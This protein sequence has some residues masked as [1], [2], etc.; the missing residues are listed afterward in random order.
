M[1]DILSAL[2]NELKLEVVKWHSKY[3]V[4]KEIKKTCFGKNRYYNVKMYHIRNY[5]GQVLSY[6]E[7]EYEHKCFDVDGKYIFFCKCDLDKRI[8]TQNTTECD[9]SICI[10]NS[11]NGKGF[12]IEHIYKNSFDPPNVI[13]SVIY[14]NSSE[15][16]YFNKMWKISGVLQRV[17][18]STD[19][20][21]NGTIFVNDDGLIDIMK[22]LDFNINDIHQIMLKHKF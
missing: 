19:P 2:P 11:T 1:V 17:A 10:N 9:N 8:A 20:G 5:L 13:F 6:G 4:T 7:F 3:S 14:Q 22:D 18:C 15:T 16:H 21:H 12:D